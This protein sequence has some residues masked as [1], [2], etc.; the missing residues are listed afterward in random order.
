MQ[1]PSSVWH[2]PPFWQKSQTL[3]HCSPYLSAGHPND[4]NSTVIGF[5]LWTHFKT[6]TIHASLC[7]KSKISYSIYIFIEFQ[8]LSFRAHH[9][10]V[11]KFTILNIFQGWLYKA[12]VNLTTDRTKRCSEWGENGQVSVDIWLNRWS[13]N[14]PVKERPFHM[15]GGRERRFPVKQT[16]PDVL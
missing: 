10:W 8:I 14:T 6:C 5:T 13:D 16:F 1:Y 11:F 7:E 9:T 4:I 3:L 2:W 12:K 15:G